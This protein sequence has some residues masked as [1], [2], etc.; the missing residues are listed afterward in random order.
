MVAENCSPTPAESVGFVIRYPGVNHS[1]YNHA[2]FDDDFEDNPEAFDLSCIASMTIDIDID[3]P[4]DELLTVNGDFYIRT[5]TGVYLTDI[6]PANDLLAICSSGCEV[7][8]QFL[9]DAINDY[10]PITGQPDFSASVEG[11]NLNIMA[12][13]GQNATTN[14]QIKYGG[15]N[16]A[17][18]QLWLSSIPGTTSN[19][20]F[21]EQPSCAC[22]NM[23]LYYDYFA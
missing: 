15:A 21:S 3:D 1:N 12:P 18:N 2:D 7:I 5:G 4:C 20:C 16:E 11:C 9:A 22:V 17:G 13:N 19:S 14:Y 23:Q 8:A 10:H 6:L